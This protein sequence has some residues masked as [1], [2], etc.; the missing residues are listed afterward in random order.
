MYSDKVQKDF[1]FW[2]SR[3]EDKNTAWCPQYRVLCEVH[4]EADSS[5]V[6]CTEHSTQS[7]SKCFV[8][9]MLIKAVTVCSHIMHSLLVENPSW[10][11]NSLEVGLCA[12]RKQIMC[13]KES[14][15]ELQ[16]PSLS[17]WLKSLQHHAL[18][19]NKGKQNTVYIVLPRHTV[20]KLV[21]TAVWDYD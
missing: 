4:P 21:F 17:W 19:Q 13:Y 5:I 16:A 6:Q 14:L 15:S 8:R 1:N 10:V 3:M 9:K 20:V 18:P 12:V 2:D 7:L 11:R